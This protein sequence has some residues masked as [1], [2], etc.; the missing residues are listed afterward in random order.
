MSHIDYAH[1]HTPYPERKN[2]KKV[3]CNTVRSYESLCLLLVMVMATG[4][5]KK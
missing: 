3:Q 4:T 2:D 5:P 1:T